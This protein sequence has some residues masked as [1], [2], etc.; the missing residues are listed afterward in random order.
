MVGVLASLQGTVLVPLVSLLP[1]IYDV[2]AVN[3]SWILTIALLSG[4]VATPIV[5]RLADMY[6]KRRLLVCT[7]MVMV[8]GSLLVATSD[9]FALAVVGRAMQGFS[10]SLTPVAMSIVKDVLPDH[11]VGPAI[12]MVSGTMGLGATIGLSLAGVMY[13]QL[14][15]ESL[16]WMMAVLAALLA[17]AARAT[18]PARPPQA[19]ERFDFNG[20]FLLV[21]GLSP[22]LLVIAQG[23]EWGWGSGQVWQLLLVSA[24]SFTVWIPWELRCSAPLIDLRLARRRSLAM[25]NVAAFAVSIGML[26]NLIIASYQLATPSTVKGGLGLSTGTAGLLMAAPTVVLIVGSPLIGRLLRQFG[27]KPLLFSGALVM[28]ASYVSRVLLDDTIWQVVLSTMLVGAGAG[29]AFASLP[30]IIMSAVQSSQAASAN[31]VNTLFRMMGT[32]SSTAAIAAL[33]ASTSVHIREVAFPTERTYHL[34]FWGCAV[35]SLLAAV[36]ASSIPRG[37]DKPADGASQTQ[38][39]GPVLRMALPEQPAHFDTAEPS[40]PAKDLVSTH[41]QGY[42]GRSKY[43][44][45][46]LENPFGKERP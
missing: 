27:G 5:S 1:K 22:L 34:A 25:T 39:P 33:T 28:S 11:R 40:G 18:L 32:A 43:L 12:A 10:G 44:F 3:A 13:A 45:R 19:L 26:T 36:L 6:G 42:A 30:M 31:G 16:F 15:W 14:G 35:A 46:R 29:F 9:N 2:S 41:E 37:S 24:V 38:R 4:A 7:L 21:L 8:M 20:A 23:N 17:V